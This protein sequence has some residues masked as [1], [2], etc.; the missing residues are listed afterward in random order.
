MAWQWAYSAFGDKQATLGAKRF[1]NETTNPTTGSTTLVHQMLLKWALIGQTE[2]EWSA[3]MWSASA[4]S[5]GALGAPF[6]WY[7][8]V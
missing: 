4:H 7:A 8:I 3:S 2:E 1:T 5:A 6:G